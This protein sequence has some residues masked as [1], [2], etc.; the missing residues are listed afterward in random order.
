M[1]KLKR[2]LQKKI[3]ILSKINPYYKKDTTKNIT[4]K[5]IDLIKIKILIN[6][7]MNKHSDKVEIIAEI[8]VNHNGSIPL[9]KKL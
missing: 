3:K 1:K 7:F 6:I 5:I 4:K 2:I 8:G 9:A